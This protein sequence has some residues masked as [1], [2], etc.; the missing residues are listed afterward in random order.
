MV[1]PERTCQVAAD[2]SFFSAL[3]IRQLRVKSRKLLGWN[4]YSASTGHYL[5]DPLR[6]S[7]PTTL[8]RER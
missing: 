4:L 7:R 3:L 5:D 6:E 8:T 2:T 1:A